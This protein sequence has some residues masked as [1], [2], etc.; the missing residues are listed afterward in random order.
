M[1]N[2]LSNKKLKQ[3]SGGVDRGGRPV[4]VDMSVPNTRLPHMP[5][6][7]KMV[8]TTMPLSTPSIVTGSASQPTS[9]T[10]KK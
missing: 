9:A 6:E 7:V 5:V 3:A 8:T 4:I 10:T 1:E 2:K